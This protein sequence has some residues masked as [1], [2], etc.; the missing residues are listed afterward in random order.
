MIQIVIMDLG[1]APL[2][3][4]AVGVYAVSRYLSI[5]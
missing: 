5:S 4:R 2:R 3:S 1:E